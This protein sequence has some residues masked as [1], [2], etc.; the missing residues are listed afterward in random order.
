MMRNMGVAL[1]VIAGIVLIGLIA[2]FPFPLWV[3]IDVVIIIVC[4]GIGARLLR[5]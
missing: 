1:L 5:K 3:A 2:R 4:A